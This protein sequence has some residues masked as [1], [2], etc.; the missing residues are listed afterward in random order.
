MK[1]IILIITMTTLG[2]ISCSTSKMVNQWKSPT[3]DVFEANKVL[4]IGMSPN[5]DTRMAFEQKLVDVLDKRGVRAVKSIDF[6]EQSFT[7]AK[8][9]ENQLNEIENQLLE[10]GFDA[11]LF[12]T[13][14]GSENKVTAVQSFND[15]GNALESFRDYYYTNQHVFYEEYTRE[16]YQVYHT[17]SAL[18]CICPDKERELLWKGYID[19][20]DPQKV[21]KSVSDYVKVLMK[22]LESQQLLVVQ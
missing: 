10:A 1:K 22:V 17:E 7:E 2:L 14:T 19:V 9:S 18:Y 16:I 15:L 12:T 21:K 13:V 8:Q 20:I 6:F 4:V 3:T 11:I 5:V